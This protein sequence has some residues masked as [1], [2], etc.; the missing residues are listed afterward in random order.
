MKDYVDR[1]P[2]DD[3]PEGEVKYVF[4]ANMSHG[5]KEI[6]PEMDNYDVEDRL[7]ER[8]V[9]LPENQRDSE[10]CQMNIWF[11]SEEEADKFIDRLNTYMCKKVQMME[12]ALNF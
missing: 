11:A 10:S 1:V 4:S 5:F 2:L 3:E 9:I 8:G 6:F 7:W 12:D